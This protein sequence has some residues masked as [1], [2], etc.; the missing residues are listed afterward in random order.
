MVGHRLY[1]VG[2]RTISDE[3]SADTGT[4]DRTE[5]NRAE[6]LRTG[7]TVHPKENIRKFF[8]KRVCY[9]HI[10]YDTTNPTEMSPIMLWISTRPGPGTPMVRT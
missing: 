2:Q 10:V 7:I 4:D 1:H 5:E 9:S 3:R 8:G 6:I